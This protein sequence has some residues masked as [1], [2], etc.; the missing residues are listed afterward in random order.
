M[1]LQSMLRGLGLAGPCGSPTLG[2]GTSLSGWQRA[3]IATVVV[4]ATFQTGRAQHGS[5]Q[6]EAACVLLRAAPASMHSSRA[7]LLLTLLRL[8]CQ[9]LS[10]SHWSRPLLLRRAQQR[11]ARRLLH[12]PLVC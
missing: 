9:D 7:G 8:L 1:T 3:P 12:L 2:T 6:M 5:W 4:G 10:A 11:L